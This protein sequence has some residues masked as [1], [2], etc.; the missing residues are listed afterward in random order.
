MAK[1]EEKKKSCG[2]SDNC[3]CSDDCNCT[4]ENKCNPDCTCGSHEQKCDCGD[5]CNCSEDCTCS[6]ECD[7]EDNCTCSDECDCGCHEHEFVDR[8]EEFKA[9]QKAFDQ[10]EEALEKVDRE[11]S[12][13]KARADKN[14]HLADSYKR[15]LERYKERNKDIVRES[16]LNAA[17]Q[18]AEKILPI[19]D[20]FEQALKTVKDENVMVGFKMIQTGITN[21]LADMEIVEIKAIGE[22]F[23]PEFHDAVNIIKTEDE[24]LDNTVA[25]VYKKGY[26]LADDSKVIR[27]SQVEIYKV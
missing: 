24:K 5:N 13:E 1:K 8:A 17:I 15:D 27:H 14:E 11:L 20:N 12:L 7:C 19:L 16:K 4:E 21:I 3:I 23:N 22:V 10:F 9:Y 18:M 6:D 25:N 2:C 26:K